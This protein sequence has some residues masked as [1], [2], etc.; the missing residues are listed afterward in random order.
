[1]RSLVHVD[2]CVYGVK[3]VEV[4]VFVCVCSSGSDGTEVVRF[5]NLQ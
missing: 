4:P 3:V 5:V 1:V 2:K